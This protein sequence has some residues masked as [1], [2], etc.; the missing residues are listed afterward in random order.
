[1]L[2]TAYE[3]M[4]RCYGAAAL[5][6]WVSFC[7]SRVVTPSTE[8]EQAFRWYHAPLVC[9]GGLPLWFFGP[10]VLGWILEPFITCVWGLRPDQEFDALTRLIGL[11]GQVAAAST[12]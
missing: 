1:M 12:S 3:V 11:Y 7:Q 9:T 8:E 5:W 2:W 6:M 10:N 4:S